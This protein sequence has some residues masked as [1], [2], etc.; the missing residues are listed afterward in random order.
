MQLRDDAV[1]V[2]A[3]VADERPAVRPPGWLD[4]ARVEGIARQGLAQEHVDS[5]FFIHVG[6]VVGPASVQVVQVETRRSEIHQRLKLRLGQGLTQAGSGVEGEVMVGEL[7]EIGVGRRYARV[8]L[9]ILLGLWYGLFRRRGHFMASRFRSDRSNL[10]PGR[11]GNSLVKPPSITASSGSCFPRS[12]HVPW[13]INVVVW[14]RLLRGLGLP[15]GRGLLPGPG[16]GPLGGVFFPCGLQ[17]I[18]KH[19][20]LESPGIRIRLQRG[21]PDLRCSRNYRDGKSC[22][23]VIRRDR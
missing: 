22:R 5:I 9:G 14:R 11:S 23:E 19:A 6:L 20:T 2:V 3:G 15:D 16:D 8:L 4:R 7:P 17:R 12:R 21:D 1:L 18:G 10:A 13:R